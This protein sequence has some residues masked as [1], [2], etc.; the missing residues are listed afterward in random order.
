MEFKVKFSLLLVLLCTACVGVL[1]G[2][3]A[4]AFWYWHEPAPQPHTTRYFRVN[5]ELPEAV[6][7]APVYFACDDEGTIYV[8]DRA[9]KRNQHWKY[10]R[11]DIGPH[12][13]KGK[14]TIAFE[15][16]NVIGLAGIIFRGEILL[17]NNVFIPIASNG[18]VLSAFSVPEGWQK[19]EFDDSAW[20]KAA[21]L[22]DGSM[23]PWITLVDM[24][25]FLG[26][27]VFPEKPAD[28]GRIPLDDF[29]DISS[30]L[31]GFGEGAR[32]GSAH[33]FNFNFGSVPDPRRDDGW[34]GA[35][36]FDTVA[37][38]G[39]ARFSKNSIFLLKLRPQAVL[40]SADAEGHSGEVGFVFRDRFD[41]SYET[42]GVKIEGEGWRD[43]RLELNAE[44]VPGFDK[45]IYPIAMM[46]IH[47][48]NDLPATGRILL[49][50]FYYEG[51]ITKPEH[52]I[53]IHPDYEKLDYAP[54]ENVT[55]SYRFR[56]GRPEAVDLALELKVL[57][58]DRKVLLQ[59]KASLKLDAFGFGRVAFNLGGFDRKGGYTVELA[60]KNGKVTANHLGWLGIF[61]ANHGRVN[62][63]PMWFGIEDQEVNTAPYEAELHAKWMK[64]LGADMMR[65][66]FL[67]A[68]AEEVPGSSFGFD[69]FRKLWQPH[70]DAG[71]M[72]CLDYAGAIPAWTQ[73][74]E[75]RPEG[76]VWPMG[77]NPELFAQH[78]RAVG[79]FMKSVPAIRWFEW[80]N[81][82]NLSRSVKLPEYM[83]S[84]QQLYPILKEIDP[85][86]KVGTG[87]LVVGAHPNAIP[88]FVEATY[89]TH[90][91][92]Y[93]I[94]LYHGHDSYQTYKKI[95]VD[96]KEM[97]AKKGLKRPVG[98]TEAGYRSYQGDPNLFYHQ[99]RQ[100]I[101]KITCSRA[102]EIEFYVWFMLQDY[103]DKYIN[104][105][106]SFGLV[107]VDN[108]PKPSFV[109]YNEL[110][111]QLADTVPAK[112]PM[113]LDSRLESYQF[114]TGKEEV[115]VA[116]PRQSG[117]LFS[118]CLQ[119][120]KPVRIID[121]FGNVTELKPVD[122]VIFVNS[123]KDPFYLRVEKGALK[124]V[125]EL[126]RVAGSAIR[127]PG[128]K[129]PL[130]LE[131][132]NPFRKEIRYSV[133]YEGV[134]RTG[135]VAAGRNEKL[136]FDF[137][138]K[139]DAIPGVRNYFAAVELKDAKDR[140]LF[141]GDLRFRLYG[142]QAV[143]A[144]AVRPIILDS[145]AV[146]TEL[147]FDP[148]T[149]RWAGKEDLSAEIRIRWKGENLA[150]EADVRDQDHS[151]AST[152]AMNWRNDS[153]QLAFADSKGAHNEITVSD[154]PGNKPIAW[155]HIA[156]GD[157]GIGAL[158]I[159]LT[160]QRENN[161]TRYRFEIP[162]K[163]LGINPVKGEVFRMSFLV[164]DNDHGKRLRVMEHFG[165]IEGSK[166]PELFGHFQLQ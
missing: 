137:T 32:P 62:Q 128:S 159:P 5:F 140:L 162:C 89:I 3:E 4:P 127:L 80:Y 65:G 87:G 9:V 155:R 41:R 64:V 13:R 117:A 123:H 109:A 84:L 35:L 39:L 17:K 121:M 110:I 22:G 124:P 135:K 93:D 16:K 91:D 111:R 58:S 103:W 11:I 139:S 150:F 36:N 43:Y 120:T 81:E 152:G 15:V 161:I 105:D 28:P 78:I 151:A 76:A 99:A 154:G 119:S 40:F 74:K 19:A 31:G 57:D 51:D 24:S 66:G 116:W 21:K 70:V 88:G 72:I 44:T 115:F 145:R 56:N 102:E 108:Q 156:P 113:E 69:G 90:A 143:S 163:L 20:Q 59:R 55:L 134:T 48:R 33:P 25:P 106:D 6:S 104:A 34:A 60:A 133:T 53:S 136:S 125:G 46:S 77:R 12:L 45:I 96:V 61:K 138:L 1:S 71:L 82:P 130:T 158:D 147:A 8:N 85:A 68:K 49:D 38:R 63:T 146:L 118:F 79:E 166:D 144:D 30:W 95:T 83:K 157:K 26:G 92:S 114:A 27:E 73:G 7:S 52:Q 132:A 94:A 10:V 67:G 165:G 107:T 47:Y 153:I 86:V 97:L 129:E 98:N 37:P 75:K 141:Q 131:L 29:A 122:G 148:T 112:E 101:Q 126:I 23:K 18:N 42:K 142:A 14:N 100:L 2:A 160:V 54:K 149:P 164:N 50:D